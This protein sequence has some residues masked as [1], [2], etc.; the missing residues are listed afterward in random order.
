[1]TPEVRSIFTPRR[2]SRLRMTWRPI[3]VLS[4]QF[5]KS[6]TSSNPKNFLVFWCFQEPKL[7]DGCFNCCF[8]GFNFSQDDFFGKPYIIRFEV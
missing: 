3:L 6:Q 7:F 8:A 2:A 4:T 1:M 5:F